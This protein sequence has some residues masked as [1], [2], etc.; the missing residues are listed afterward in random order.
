MACECVDG[1]TGVED[2][3]VH[4][5][6]SEWDWSA[7]GVVLP[8]DFGASCPGRWRGTHGEVVTPV[9]NQH[10]VV[11]LGVDLIKHGK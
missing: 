9:P 3:S 6:L 10:T 11:I 2:S 1:L 7:G 5:A 4:P 8:E